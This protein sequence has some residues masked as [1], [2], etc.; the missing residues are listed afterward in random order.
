MGIHCNSSAKEEL[1]NTQDCVF[2][3]SKRL[4]QKQFSS[5]YRNLIKKDWRVKYLLR[6]GLP[7]YY[8]NLK[9]IIHSMDTGGLYFAL[10]C[11][12]TSCVSK[13]D[14]K[15]NLLPPFWESDSINSPLQGSNHSTLKDPETP[16]RFKVTCKLSGI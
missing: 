1:N 6:Y 4:Y 9:G 2:Y 15:D 14:L 16:S 13:G 3:Y 5:H 11:S 10:R 8:R 12:T 7:L